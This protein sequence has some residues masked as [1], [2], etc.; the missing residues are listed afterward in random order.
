MIHRDPH[1]RASINEYILRWNKDVF[2]KSFHQVFFQV[3]ST[4]LRPQYMFSDMKIA[5]IRKYINSIWFTCFGKRH[6]SVS[7]SF[8]E[9]IEP[10]VFERIREDSIKEYEAY[11]VPSNELFVFLSRQNLQAMYETLTDDQQRTNNEDRDSIIV[12]VHW[13]GALLTTCFYP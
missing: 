10:F 3:A 1:K 11:L 8:N 13:I 6:A 7:E 9:P 5:I 12:T 2:P 4:Y